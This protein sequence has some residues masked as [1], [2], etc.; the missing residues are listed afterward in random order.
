MS[1]TDF[2]V[3]RPEGDVVL[4]SLEIAW[5]PAEFELMLRAPVELAGQTYDRLPLREPT[6]D[7][8]TKIMAAPEGQRRRLGIFLVTGIPQGAVAKMG[9]GDTVRAEAYLSS[10]FDIGQ[11]IGVS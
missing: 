2:D 10:F 7:E 9:I 4:P 6:D 11:A 5:P 1:E 3:E 8:W